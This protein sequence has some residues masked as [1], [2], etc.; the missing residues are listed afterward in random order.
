[1]FCL[2]GRTSPA[3]PARTLGKPSSRRIKTI[4]ELDVVGWRSAIED[5]LDRPDST[6]ILNL[7]NDGEGVYDA[8]F[9]GGG[10]AGR[11]GGSYL[12]AMGGRAL[13]IDR[14]PFLGGT[15][16]HQA[17][18]PHHLFSEA[19]A[20][21]D[22]A[23]WFSGELF[24]AEFDPERASILD[25][26]ELFRGGR[27][28][29]HA[30]MNWQTQ[31]QLEVEF[32][33]NAEAQIIDAGTVSAAG[34]TFSARNLVIGLGAQQRPL[35]IPGGDLP[36]V[37]DWVTLVE[38]L[39]YEPRR[40]VIVGGGKVA[41]EYGAFF[42][43]TGCETTIV[44][45]SPVMRTRSLHHVDEDV[46]RYVVNGMRAR[47]MTLLEG[48]NV[49]AIEGDGRVERVVV[50]HPDGSVETI[51]CD[52]VFNCTG[53]RP[54]S[55]HAVAALGVATGPGGEI[56]VDDHMRTSVD[57]V[58]AAGDVIGSPMEMFKAR[59]C[60]MT[61]ARNVMGEDYTFDFSEY[62]DFLHTTYEVSWVGLSEEEARERYDDIA[63]IRMPPK[64]QERDNPLPCAEG[65]MLYA[66]AKPELSG[67]QKCIIDS[68]SRRILG[69]HHVGYGAKDAFQYLDYLLRRP[70][71][72]TIDELGEM[73]ELFLNPEHFIQL[74]RLR[75]GRRALVDL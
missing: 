14:W 41:V 10:A 73:N 1:M 52:F 46:R 25:L 58:Y 4:S 30:F 27:S 16:P 71:G 44:S 3:R 35:T 39:D 45:R 15:C 26:V 34:R 37:H 70:E 57:G 5:A 29:A 50:S 55:D 28:T 53:E 51:E 20:L 60:G 69:F 11:F 13:I 56:L 72:L 75:A 19:A 18:V 54:N 38:D 62:P 32:V 8:I 23:R 47:G 65:T 24:F 43:A 49:T 7:D 36:G 12:R 67:L 59:K 2:W 40:C 17:C 42:H 74:S 61:A 6:P 48:A 64:G 63:V 66:F 22:R 9:V 21:L 33:L 31:V 68:S